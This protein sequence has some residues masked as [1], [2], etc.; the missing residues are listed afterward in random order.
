MIMEHIFIKMD[1]FLSTLQG[2]QEV[3]LRSVKPIL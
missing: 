2:P 1:L 3:Q